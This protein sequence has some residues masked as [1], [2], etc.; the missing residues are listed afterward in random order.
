MTQIQSPSMFN[1]LFYLIC[2]FS[3]LNAYS[4]IQGR[5]NWHIVI[6]MSETTHLSRF[7]HTFQTSTCYIFDLE[8]KDDQLTSNTHHFKNDIFSNHHHI[9]SMHIQMS[10]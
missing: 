2:K 10:H 1:D 4:N 8:P 6:Q 5:L 7:C 3:L 9:H